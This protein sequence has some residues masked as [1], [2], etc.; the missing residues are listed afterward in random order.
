[1]TTADTKVTHPPSRFRLP[2]P[3]ERETDDMTSFD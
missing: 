1:M 2:D 3:P